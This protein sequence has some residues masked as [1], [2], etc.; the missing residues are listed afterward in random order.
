MHVR[1]KVAFDDDDDGDA[2]FVSFSKI[3]SK[4]ELSGNDDVHVEHLSEVGCGL[5]A[6]ASRMS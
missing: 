1:S 6:R 3:I 4:N 5:F 2:A